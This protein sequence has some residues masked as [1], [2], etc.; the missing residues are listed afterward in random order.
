VLF[1]V[2]AEQG[3][4]PGDRFIS[5]ALLQSSHRHPVVCAVNKVD[6]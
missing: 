1:V 5:K 3:V 6:R 4:G 2:N